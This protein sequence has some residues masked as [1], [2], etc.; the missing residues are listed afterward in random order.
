MILTSELI[1]QD[2]IC[3]GIIESWGNHNNKAFRDDLVQYVAVEATLGL[4][5]ANDAAHATA[6]DA[7]PRRR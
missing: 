6:S 1:L 7:L 2:T 5:R 3:Q 4:R